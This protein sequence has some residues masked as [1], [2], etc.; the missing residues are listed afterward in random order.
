MSARVLSTP[1]GTQAAQ[2]LQAILS[3]SLAGDLKQIQQAGQTLSNPN[4]WDGPDAVRFRSQWASESRV[5]QQAITHLDQLQK[6]AQTIL[7]TIMQAG[8]A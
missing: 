6:Q 4:D 2:R 8:G 3:G 1:Q 5:L 7:Q